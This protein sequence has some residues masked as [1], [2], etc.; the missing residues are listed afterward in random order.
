MEFQNR[1]MMDEKVKA[2]LLALDPNTMDFNDIKKF[3]AKTYNAKDKKINDPLIPRN[4]KT[5]LKAGEYINTTDIETIP[6]V[7]LYNKCIVEGKLDKF[8]PGGFYNPPF[9]NAKAHNKL[10]SYLFPALT[11]GKIDIEVVIKFLDD[12]ETWGMLLMAPF[13]PSFTPGTIS[14]H[15]EVMKEKEKL[16]TELK[17]KTK[18][19]KM[20]INDML[21]IEDKL[22]AMNKSLLKG[23]PG[24]TLYDSGARG[25][26]DNDF[27]N[28]NIIIG[29]MM[30]PETG[31]FDLVGSNYIDGIQ[32]SDLARAGNSVVNGAYPKAVGTQVGGYM[33]KQFYAVFQ[34]MV[35][36]KEGTDCGSTGYLDLLLDEKSRV[37]V[38]YRYIFDGNKEVYLDD[39]NIDKYMN[40][41]LKIR[42][43]QFCKSEK[44]CSHCMG[45]RY[46]FMQMEN[47]GAATVSLSNDLLNKSMKSNHVSKVYL[48]EVDVNK[49]LL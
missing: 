35:V 43:P 12:M 47:V 34:S 10:T 48:N 18:G 19:G 1:T 4:T 11:Q 26:F 6:G 28:N 38:L 8:I 24:M 23:D 37:D 41:Y 22:V 5:K 32:K 29:P 7:I 45:K 2:M 36:D 30:N 27:K 25:S 33:T 46:N 44:F 31:E 42:S 40:R 15:P 17:E 3:F 13:S 21:I 20:S 49:L 16:I 39:D 9:I 14:S